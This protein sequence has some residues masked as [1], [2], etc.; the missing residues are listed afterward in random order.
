MSTNII[1]ITMNNIIKKIDVIQNILPWKNTVNI[2]N[3]FRSI[4]HLIPTAQ[5]NDSQAI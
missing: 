2:M 4:Q 5:T 1:F 3:Y